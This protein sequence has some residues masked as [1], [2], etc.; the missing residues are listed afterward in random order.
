MLHAV[1]L[2]SSKETPG[3]VYSGTDASIGET[4]RRY[5][6]TRNCE[7]RISA[8]R[9]CGLNPTLSLKRPP[10]L[11]ELQFPSVFSALRALGSRGRGKFARAL[12]IVDGMDDLRP[13][14]PLLPVSSIDTVV[15]PVYCGEDRAGAMLHDQPPGRVLNRRRHS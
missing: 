4:F 12:I 13:E 14:V 3:R 8:P 6:L 11:G 15:E 2:S 7:S 9:I 10:A 1:S 5:D